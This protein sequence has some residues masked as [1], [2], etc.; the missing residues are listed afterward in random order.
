[1]IRRGKASSYWTVVTQTW[2]NTHARTHTITSTLAMYFCNVCC[3]GGTGSF[4]SLSSNLYIWP[5]LYLSPHS[6]G[7]WGNSSLGWSCCHLDGCD[8]EPRRGRDLD[9]MEP[10]RVWEGIYIR[11]NQLGDKNVCQVSIMLEPCKSGYV[12]C[13]VNSAACPTPAH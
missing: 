1:M 6:A 10:D 5:L 4:I 2:R 3:S 9:I 12:E 11:E 7:R 8:M 13:S